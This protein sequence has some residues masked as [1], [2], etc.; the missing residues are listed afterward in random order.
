MAGV[1][2]LLAP[3]TIFS[4]DPKSPTE[5]IQL[6]M[7]MNHALC[8]CQTTTAQAPFFR[9]FANRPSGWITTI[10]NRLNVFSRTQQYESKS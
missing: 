5:T 9:K 2:Q 1:W 3:I 8:I 6:F 10:N 7:Q 4:N